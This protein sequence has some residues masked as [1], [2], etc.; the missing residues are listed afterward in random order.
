M[1]DEVMRQVF[2]GRKDLIELLSDELEI[3]VEEHLSSFYVDSKREDVSLFIGKIVVQKDRK[4]IFN[5]IDGT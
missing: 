5:F 2:R 3:P 4:L 1:L